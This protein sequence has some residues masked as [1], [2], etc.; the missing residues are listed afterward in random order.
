MRVTNNEVAI[1]SN[2]IVIISNYRCDRL[3]ENLHE[4]AHMDVNVETVVDTV[5][6]N[7]N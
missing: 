1:Y 6:A 4:Y 5:V 3:V 7:I 2:R